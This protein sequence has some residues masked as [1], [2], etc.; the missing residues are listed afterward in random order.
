MTAQD[1][2][3]PNA[4]T[5]AVAAIWHEPRIEVIAGVGHIAAIQAPAELARVVVE[6]LT[7]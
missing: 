7:S 2:L 5:L 4:A 1:E 6:F 3:I